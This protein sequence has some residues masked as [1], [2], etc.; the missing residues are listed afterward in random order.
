MLSIIIYYIIEA[1][2]LMFL[3]AIFDTVLNTSVYTGIALSSPLF[4]RYMCA[5]A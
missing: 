1:L 4:I 2:K 5:G 3:I